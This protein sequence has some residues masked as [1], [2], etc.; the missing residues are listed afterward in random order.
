ME[1]LTALGLRSQLDAMSEA[2]Q[3]LTM[4]DAQAGGKKRLEMMA[5]P[6]SKHEVVRVSRPALRRMLYEVCAV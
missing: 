2:G 6:G 4:Y 1:A 5:Q 3:G